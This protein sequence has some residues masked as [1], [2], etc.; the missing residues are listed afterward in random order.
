M[1]MRK[2]GC[3]LITVICLLSVTACQSP[4]PLI[5]STQNN[6]CDTQS[7]ICAAKQQFSDLPPQAPPSAI[8]G[9]ATWVTHP[10]WMN[11]HISVHGQQM[12]FSFWV[13][14]ILDPTG[15][16]VAY[17][18]GL[19]QNFLVSM[20]YSGPVSGALDKL[21]AI[22]GYAYEVNGST[23]TWTA[24]ETKTFDVSFMPGASQ[25]L[26]G[27]QANSN[28]AAN[29]QY[30]NNAG[31]TMTGQTMSD[32]YSN[33]QGTLSVWSD[34]EHT[35]HTMLSKDGQVF[36][37]QATTT[38]TVRDHPQNVRVISEYLNSMNKD[39]SRQVALQVQVLQITLNKAFS[40]GINWDL[41]SQS[42]SVLGGVGTAGVGSG[43]TTSLGADL[44]NLGGIGAT[45]IGVGLIPHN[46]SKAFINAIQQQGTV[47]TVTQPRVVTLNNQVAQ[48]A[49]TQQKTYLASIT[50][51]NTIDVG[52]Q[53]SLT[54]G[55]VTTGF[56]M[57]VLP[58]IIGD[59]VYLQ[60]TSELS[61]LDSLDTFTSST[62]SS[63]LVGGGSASQIEGPTVSSKSFN[64]RTMV[65]SGESLIL[66]G[67]RQV[68]NENNQSSMFGIGPL[69]GMGAQQDNTEVLVIITP[70]IVGANC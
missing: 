37:S 30:N 11:Q 14:K 48:I 20:D 12:P 58:K 9:P 66:S 56:T 26:M 40:Y 15:A 59:D 10:A 54:P 6:V 16:D 65:P 25:Y 4:M 28:T 68:K 2:L 51:T 33:L 23:V 49:I 24:Y 45:G 38:I 13:S 52:T 19:D 46:A 63:S 64:Q 32:Q 5:H 70:I 29:S 47:S 41:V 27:Q 43:V 55:E 3:L 7:Q 8:M 21:A 31:V 22:S 39:L 1:F 62:G 36:V 18:D 50:T 57:F 61:N 17:Q 35:I 60:L 53:T 44:T 34:L 42:L 67:F 69:G